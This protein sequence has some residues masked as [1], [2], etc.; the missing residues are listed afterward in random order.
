MKKLFLLFA[1]LGL[2]CLMSVADQK[3]APDSAK[4]AKAIPATSASELVPTAPSPVLNN[5]RASNSQMLSA[6]APGASP[7]FTAPN[8]HQDELNEL[9]RQRKE[10]ELRGENLKVIDGQILQVLAQIRGPR[11]PGNPLD[12]GSDYCPALVIP[13]IPYSD[14]GT[15]AGMS[16]DF[17]PSCGNSSASDVVYQYTPVVSGTHTVSLCGSGFDTELELR[18]GGGCPGSTVVLCNDDFCGLQSEITIMPLYAGTTYYIIVDGYGSNSGNYTLTVTGPPPPSGPDVCPGLTISA[19]PFTDSQNTSGMGNEYI[20]ACG[21]PSAADAVYTFTPTV[22]GTYDVSLCGSGYDTMLDV[23][24]GGSCPGSTSLACNDDYCGTGSQV[25]PYLNAGTTYYI[26]VDGYASYSGNYTLNVSRQAPQGDNCTNPIFMSLP[27]RGT[28]STCS[29]ANDYDY[30]CSW[31]S[32][33]SD[34]VYFYSPSTDQQVSFSLCRSSYDTKLYVYQNSCS[35]TPIACSDDASICPCASASFRSYLECLQ[36]YAGNTYYV[37]V[38]GYGG[39]C[40]D[41]VLEAVMCPNCDVTATPGDVIE[42][43]EDCSNPTFWQTDPD[44]GCN[45]TPHQFSSVQNGQTIFGHVFTYRYG[46]FVYRDTDWYLFTLAERDTV[47]LIAWGAEC[48]LFVS[49]VDTSNCTVAMSYMNPSECMSMDMRTACLN[50]GTYALVIAPQNYEGVPFPRD[51]RVQINWRPC[52]PLNDNCANAIPLTVNAATP[53]CGT[54]LGS[55]RDCAQTPIEMTEVWYTFSLSQCMDISVQYCG[56][57]VYG[58]V[59]NRLFPGSCCGTNYTMLEFDQTTC[60]DARFTFHWGGLSPGQYWLPVAIVPAGDFCIR[61]VGTTGPPSNDQCANAIVVGVN[62][63]N[64]GSTVCAT[65]DEI[66]AC[67]SPAT[68]PGVWHKVIGT[69]DS[70]MATLCLNETNYNSR[71]SVFTCGCSA[72]VCAAENDNSNCFNPLVSQVGWCSRLG[73][74]YLIL[75]HGYGTATGNYGLQ[76]TDLGPACANPSCCLPPQVTGV[77]ATDDHCNNVVI[78][79]NDVSNEDGYYV[80]RNGGIVD[81][82]DAN[83]T[84]GVDTPAP[85]TYAYI[86]YAYNSCG[87]GFQSLSDNG[88]RLAPPPQVTGVAATD[89]SCNNIVITWN[90]VA[91][92]NGYYVYRNGQQVC[93]VGANILTCTDTP[94]TGT[95]SYTVSGWNTCGTGPASLPDQGLLLPTVTQAPALGNPGNGAVVLSGIVQQYCWLAVANASTYRIQWDDDAQFGSPVAAN[96]AA[97]CYNQILSAPLGIWYWRVRGENTCGPGPWSGVQTVL[98]ITL[99]PPVLVM[100]VD[101]AQLRLYWNPVGFATSYDVQRSN[102]PDSGFSLLTTTPDT[103]ITTSYSVQDKLFYRVIANR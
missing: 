40:G 35:G 74:E 5:A 8:P 2:V 80:C 1:A 21:G 34:V 81:T 60:A 96:T 3:P 90:D 19:V 67:S 33:S 83:I 71:I 102:T 54:T 72:L 68:A 63:L 91:G 73:E 87:N 7:Q 43:A 44:G 47:E 38:D 50:P 51:Y 99:S 98:V 22:S 13:G 75:V 18:Y 55:T 28:G 52:A 53:T 103:T 20:P 89:N 16:N 84:N 66:P 65:L 24:Y 62:H 95:Y 37:V 56:T 100:R 59:L 86:V 36:L 32:T 57:P 11:E 31:S 39:A 49:I 26:L 14:A 23:R 69:G 58:S 29:Y 97:L 79:W 64:V 42:V 48:P 4:P 101:G 78:T 88:T 77:T 10:M 41:Y 93:S 70:L 17:T 27:F 45:S 94:P 15:T 6:I 30:A 82:V 12:Q 76:V 46:G 61:V 85:G 9:V 25:S 92:E